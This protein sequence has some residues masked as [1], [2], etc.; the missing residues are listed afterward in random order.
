MCCSS[1]CVSCF[2]IGEQEFLVHSGGYAIRDQAVLPFKVTNAAKD[3]AA[4]VI[5]DSVLV[6][7]KLLQLCLQ[8]GDFVTDVIVF[9]L[10]SG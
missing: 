3:T 5:N 6:I 7:N 10:L 2:V 1:L 8:H 9:K 4:E